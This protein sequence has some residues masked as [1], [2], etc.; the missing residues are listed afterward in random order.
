MSI[1]K[2]YY[3]E[4]AYTLYNG[5]N[6]LEEK[7]EMATP[8][9]PFKFIMG[10]DMALP[11]FEEK[12]EGL[13]KGDKFDFNLEPVNAFGDIDEQK[14]LRLKKEI[15]TD[16]NGKFDDE[17]IYEGNIVPMRTND[18]QIIQGTVNEV[19]DDFVEMDFNHPY[20]GLT[21]HFV[22]EI[23]VAREA[24][25]QDEATIHAMMHG[26]CGCGCGS[27]HDDCSSDGG[28]GC[29]GCGCGCH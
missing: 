16:P 22:G 2:G 14:I 19:G 24:T 11:A 25:E 26:S 8:E 23:L 1:T 27:E 28:C 13:S 17:N 5:E 29:G 4:C 18:N 10:I 7:L 3:I 21:L 9:A 15:F 6:N 12:L 20:A